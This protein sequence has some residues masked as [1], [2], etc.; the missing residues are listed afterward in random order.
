[1]RLEVKRTQESRKF[2][3]L[4]VAKSVRVFSALQDTEMFTLPVFN[5]SIEFEAD[6]AG[7]KCCALLSNQDH[8]V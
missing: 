5:N 6:T 3:I 4:P 1:L 2:W 8:F 7:K